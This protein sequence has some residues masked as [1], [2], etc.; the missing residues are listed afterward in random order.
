M[1]QRL[2]AHGNVPLTT[3]ISLWLFA[4]STVVLA[5][6]SILIILWSPAALALSRLNALDAGVTGALEQGLQ[7]SR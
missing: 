1:A 4:L 2:E 6:G 7:Q 3:G 5:G